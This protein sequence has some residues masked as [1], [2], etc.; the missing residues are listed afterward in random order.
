MCMIVSLSSFIV[1][2]KV[3]RRPHMSTKLALKLNTVE[4]TTIA[5]TSLV[6][7]HMD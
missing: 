5:S 4:A 1:L 2:Q 6:Y 7:S 3:Y